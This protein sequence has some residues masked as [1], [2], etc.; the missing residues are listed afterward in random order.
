MRRGLVLG[1]GGTVGGAWTVGA[2]AAV[3][4]HLAWDPRDATVIVGTSA[5]SSLAA[6]LGSGVGADDLVAAQ[7]DEDSAP[8]VARRFFTRPPRAVAPPP[9]LRPT[10]LALAGRGLL[11]GRPLEAAAGLAPAGRGST[12]FL[13]ELADGLIGHGLWVEHPACWMVAVDVASGERVAFGA[14]G[15]PVVPLRYALRAS[16]AVPGWFPPVTAHERRYLDGGVL[17][18]T[19]ADLVHTLDLDEVVVIAPMA[20][21]AGTARSGLGGRA[22]SLVLRRGMSATLA[23]EVGVLRSVGLPVLTVLPGA[24]DLAVMGANFMA[25]GRRLAALDVALRTVPQRLDATAGPSAMRR[26]G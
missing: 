1:C 14:L 4:D 26:R 12:R 20:S 7:R 5:G 24:E 6:L 13:D 17:S 8:E 21:P 25:P 19:S 15:M 11:G 10:S 18:P 3:S 23:R 22:E 16:W 2:L 9:R